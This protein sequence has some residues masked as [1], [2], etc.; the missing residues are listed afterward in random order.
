LR[1]IGVIASVVLLGLVA[2]SATGA[3]QHG[4]RHHSFIGPFTGVATGGEDR[5][6]HRDD[7]SSNP[8]NHVVSDSLENYQGRFTYSFRIENGEVAG[9]GQGV[10]TAATW[11][12]SGVNGK[13]GSFSC[14]VPLETQ[15]FSVVVNGFAVDGR[16][17]LYFTIT[18]SQERNADYDCGAK[19]TGFAT[20]SKFLAD[21][22]SSL[23]N[24]IAGGYIPTTVKSPQIPHLASVATPA[25]DTVSRVITD[26][27]DI[28]ITA[29]S[30]P[31]SDSSGGPGPSTAKR[32][33]GGTQLCTIQGTPGRDFLTGSSGRDVICGLGGNDVIRGGGGDDIVFG[34]PGNDTIDGGA[35]R[36]LLFGDAGKDV[37]TAKDGESDKVVGGAGKDRATVDK[38]KD[39]VS[40][41][42]KISG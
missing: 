4:V 5:V 29:P 38:G 21:S 37:F 26:A 8:D 39:R 17:Y 19:F 18:G 7:K 30:P 20:T 42:E 32:R 2:A 36:D 22:L 1:R 10:Y 41:V 11:H 12:L 40:A 34:G 9:T 25:G 6:S 15:A 14:D 3:R 28:S 23:Q 16:L 27:W 35:G 33:G 24:S 31:G 13:N